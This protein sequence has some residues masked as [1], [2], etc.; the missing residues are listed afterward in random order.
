MAFQDRY[1]AAVNSSNLKSAD[2]KGAEGSRQPCQR[3][4][5][6]E[7]LKNHDC[8]ECARRR[9]ADYGQ[10]NAE[11]ISAQ[12]AEYRAKNRER[13][14]LEKAEWYRANAENHKAVSAASRLR[15][16]EKYAALS[17]AWANRNRDKVRRS[18]EKW[19][20]KNPEHQKIRVHNYR[21]RKRAAGGALSPKL[22]AK[23]FA[24]QHGK[25]PCCRR[26]L[27][28]DFHLDHKMPLAL[29]GRNTDD[30]MQLLRAKCNMEKNAKHP[31]DF[32]QSRGFLL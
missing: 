18:K 23:L 31:V 12:R 30:N 14:K 15:N 3:C 28:K 21:A 32:M 27:G 9:S 10:R 22:V 2:D 1:A 5:T 17:R 13:L 20:E 29:G 19:A 26:P 11:K 25:C 8:R 4:G 7:R 24:L 6:T 16:P